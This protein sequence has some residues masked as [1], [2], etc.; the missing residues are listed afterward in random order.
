METLIRD[1][2]GASSTVQAI[3]VTVG[4]LIGVFITL[5]AFFLFIFISVRI[6]KKT[7]N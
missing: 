1:L 2:Q 5:G 4:G 7:S 6:G 3:A